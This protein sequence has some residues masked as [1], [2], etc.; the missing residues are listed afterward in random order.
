MLVVSSC[1]LVLFQN[2]M[3]GNTYSSI[4]LKTENRVPEGGIKIGSGWDFLHVFSGGKGILYAITD[5]YDL[6]YYKHQDKPTGERQF[7]IAGLRIGTGWEFKH[8]FSG[9]DGVIYAINHKN[10]LIYYKHVENP[11][12]SKNFIEPGIRIGTG[13]DF[14]KVFAGGGGIIYAINHNDDLIYYK[15][16]VNPTKD[17]NF[18]NPGYKIGAGWNFRDVFS[19]GNNIIFGIND[20]DELL[21]Y[22]HENNP[23]QEKQFVWAG[24]TFEFGWKF[25]NS[26][27]GGYGIIY[28]LTESKDLFYYDNMTIKAVM[29]RSFDYEKPSSKKEEN[30]NTPTI[31]NIPTIKIGNQLWMTEN[32]NTDRF[33]N[34]DIIP[35]AKTQR[36]W[37]LANSKKQPA[38]CSF[39]PTGVKLKGAYGKLYNWYAINDTRGLAPMGFHIPTQ[40]KCN[41]LIKTNSGSFS[42]NA[43]KD[44]YGWG[45]YSGNNSSGFSAMPSGFRSRNGEYGGVTKYWLSKNRKIVND[46]T[47]Y[48]PSSS[49]WWIKEDSISSGYESGYSGDAL[50][51]VVGERGESIDIGVESKGSGYSVRCIKD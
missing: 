42:G 51:F 40:L 21:F 50:Y 32:L 37:Q 27:T 30:V 35:E 2:P 43:L 17:I 34:G 45:I 7:P 8:V 10:E 47:E 12:T 28:G 29:S 18:E 15:H 36:E 20:K 49:C 3:I 38:W 31:A 23:N 33:R 14:K 11:T 9:G 41:I 19:G 16:I 26:M 4:E 5:N 13:W 22:Q 24:E 39:E 6:L 1:L 25:T 48:I 46:G 44:K